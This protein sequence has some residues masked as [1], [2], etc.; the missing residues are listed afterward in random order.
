[1]PWVIIHNSER[2]CV[3]KQ[4]TDGSAGEQLACFDS[5]QGAEDHLAALYA[6]VSDARKS[7]TA[8]K[9]LDEEGG[10]IGGY[11]VVWGSPAQRDLEGEYFTPQTE[12][13][14]DWYERRP[15][16]YHHGLDGT[17]KASLIGVIDSLKA[18]D[19]G[20]WAEA[21]LDMRQRYIQA[22][23]RLVKRGILN[24]SS[25]SL[26]HLA[27]IAKDGQI[28][29]WP[30]VEGSLTPTPAEP[31]QTNVRALKAVEGLETVINLE[32][33]EAK[34][35]LMPVAD[36]PP[37]DKPNE[38]VT[39][40]EEEVTMEL[41]QIVRA[42]LS[43]MM[44]ATGAQLS[45][46]QQA[47]VVQAALAAVQQD[48]AASGGEPPV[49]AVTPEQMNTTA[50]AIA[51]KVKTALDALLAE[52]E[53][54]KAALTEAAK[55]AVGGLVGR[56]GR[57]RAPGFTSPAGGVSGAKAAAAAPAITLRTKYHNL[58][59]A[60]MAFLYHIRT[61][62][63]EQP[64]V[65]DVKFWREMADKATKAL[66]GNGLD[67]LPDENDDD[68]EPVR[69]PSAIKAIA[70]I[71]ADEL[72]YTTQTGYGAE[73]VADLW[74]S[75]LWTRVRRENVVAAQFQIWDMP[76]NPWN[77]PLEGSDPTVYRAP[78]T[79]DEA[80][81]V[82]GGTNNP[83]TASKIGTASR[84]LY[85]YK[86]ALRVPISAELDEDS[87]I[88]AVPQLREQSVR[89][90]QDAI[91]YVLLN[92]DTTTGT[93]PSGNINKY[94][95][96]VASTDMDKWLLGWD[97]VLHLPLVDNDTLKLDAGNARPQLT[98]FRQVQAKLDEEYLD[99]T[100]NLVWIVDPLTH[101]AMKDMDELLT[102]DKYGPNATILTGEVGKIDG[103]PVLSSVQLKRSAPGGKI[104]TTSS[105]NTR[106]RAVLIYRPYFA[107]GYRRRIRSWIKFYEEA[108]A[109]QMGVNLRIAFKRREDSGAAAGL[110]YNLAV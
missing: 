45:E 52:G 25:G 46:E 79:T 2:F 49:M 27:E 21:Q 104:S 73:W 29:R 1:M 65:P 22:V 96:A 50:K 6:N 100:P 92:A 78:E 89:A 54:A 15:V 68:G 31:R 61:P 59:A 23:Q 14:L 62:K 12:L 71:K 93:S 13:A 26:T 8:V 84:Q 87:I 101:Q 77:V 83:V 39:Q 81:L 17:L 98:M 3:H 4:N 7:L 99:D 108:D 19:V 102:V 66:E 69:G 16:L 67:Y 37:Q 86:L 76:T 44:E 56:G 91:D 41:E 53:A 42:L 85:A 30:I 20:L 63:G 24:W 90:M 107:V 10:R 18:D 72:D 80:Q 35:V 103:I 58:S 57:S 51:P 36:P 55:A 48:A 74:R 109:Y 34:A 82:L 105:N 38:P 70:A 9:F 43:A 106:G 110:L 60:D 94:D 5:E 11:L 64:W 88:Q 47:Q 97:G 40:E 95:A 28:K 33:L 75:E 32:E